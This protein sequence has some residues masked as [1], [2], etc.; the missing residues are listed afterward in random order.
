MTNPLAKGLTLGALIA[1]AGCTS[2][3]LR[4]QPGD[5]ADYNIRSGPQ[6]QAPITPG[7][8]NTVPYNGTWPSAEA[9]LEEDLT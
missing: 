4:N 8:N 2:S 6:T 7:P 1:L 5:T 9:A 3:A